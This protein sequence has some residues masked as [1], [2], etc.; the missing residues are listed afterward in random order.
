MYRKPRSHRLSAQQEYL[1]LIGALSKG[2]LQ[3]KVKH[4]D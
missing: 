1:D 2:D 3:R 4:A